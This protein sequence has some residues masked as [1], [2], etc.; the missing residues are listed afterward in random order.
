MAMMIRVEDPIED[1]LI[2]GHCKFMYPVL[3]AEME[4][5]YKSISVLSPST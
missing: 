3:G 4:N 2:T 1:W 5:V